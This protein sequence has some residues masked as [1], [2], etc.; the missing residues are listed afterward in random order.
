MSSALPLVSAAAVDVTTGATIAASDDET[1]GA[2]V[3][4]SSTEDEGAYIGVS[5]EIKA[6]C[7]GAFPFANGA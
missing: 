4:L 2:V 3:P 6:T 1:D 7:F 5:V